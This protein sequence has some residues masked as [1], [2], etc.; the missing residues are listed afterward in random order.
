MKV[1]VSLGGE[2][3]SGDTIRGIFD[4]PEKAVTKMKT[5]EAVFNGE[6]IARPYTNYLVFEVNA[7]CDFRAVKEY[8]VQ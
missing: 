7:D 6:W 4:T 2:L 3:N 1:Y 5:Q 8:E